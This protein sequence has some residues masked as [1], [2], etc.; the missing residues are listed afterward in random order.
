MDLLEEYKL[1]DWLSLAKQEGNT[2]FQD[3][4]I[5]AIWRKELY[6]I[7]EKDNN[8]IYYE[9]LGAVIRVLF[10]HG[11][12]LSTL[13]QRVMHDKQ[14]GCK[15]WW[16]SL[17]QGVIINMLTEDPNSINNYKRLLESFCDH[18]L[19]RYDNEAGIEKTEYQER[20]LT[21]ISWF[22]LEL[23]KKRITPVYGHK[24]CYGRC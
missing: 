22:E 3:V 9:S 10:L 21:I 15:E 23:Q 16:L 24:S 6:Q 14:A 1:A 20:C 5:S 11:V 4:Y 17:F 2:V 7:L 13:M 18:P 19:V 8:A 12:S